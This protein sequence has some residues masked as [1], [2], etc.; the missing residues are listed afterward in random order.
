M[1]ALV[2]ACLRYVFNGYVVRT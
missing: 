2:H 1:L